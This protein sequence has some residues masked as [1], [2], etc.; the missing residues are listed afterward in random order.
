MM[1][2]DRAIIE[3]QRQR[4]QSTPA[5]RGPITKPQSDQVD[6]TGFFDKIFKYKFTIL[7]ISI[8]PTLAFSFYALQKPT[9]YKLTACF[10]QPDMAYYEFT[11]FKNRF[12][13]TQN[14]ARIS[15]C[16]SPCYEYS[17]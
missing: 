14:L 11:L 5:R 2:S 10:T 9:Q 1:L 13:D 15:G 6:L 16:N 3:K 8:L 7:T 17:F 4:V 12:F